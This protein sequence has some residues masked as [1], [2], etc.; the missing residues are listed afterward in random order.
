MVYVQLIG[1]A[2]W[3]L[4]FFLF[5]L[6]CFSI[7]TKA[8]SITFLYFIPIRLGEF[9]TYL[10]PGVV[11]IANGATLSIQKA[12]ATPQHYDA[13]FSFVPHS[14]AVHSPHWKA[15]LCECVSM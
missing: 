11:M 4:L 3:W 10:T 15:L 7:N 13:H 12:D 5:C 14:C 9:H 6:I 2:L 8:Q 1:L